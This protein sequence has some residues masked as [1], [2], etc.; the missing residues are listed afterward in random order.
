MRPHSAP[1]A[2]VDRVAPRRSLQV[3]D[4]ERGP[5]LG[6]RRRHDGIDAVFTSDLW[7]AIETTMIAFADTPLPILYDWRLRECDYGQV[8]TLVTVGC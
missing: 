2:R 7:R 3:A 4:A 1:H 6:A 8:L 5:L